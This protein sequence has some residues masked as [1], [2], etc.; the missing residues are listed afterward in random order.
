MRQRVAGRAE[1]AQVG[2]VVGAA[3][4]SRRDVVDFQELRVIAAGRLATVAGSCEGF[5]AAL[6]WNGRAIR[7]VG[8]LDAGIA[9]HT[10]GVDGMIAARGARFRGLAFFTRVHVSIWNV[11]THSE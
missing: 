2:K 9:V 4:C 6:R 8:A 1:D 10:P 7:L 5:P 3:L 11:Q